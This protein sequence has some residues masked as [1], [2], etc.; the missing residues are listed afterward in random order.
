MV[1]ERAYMPPLPSTWATPLRHRRAPHRPRVARRWQRSSG[2]SGEDGVD[3]DVV[4]VVTAVLVEDPAA[5]DQPKGRV[6]EVAVD[7][8]GGELGLRIGGHPLHPEAGD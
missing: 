1:V 8:G 3:D 6:V 2:R 5:G 4:R 7:V